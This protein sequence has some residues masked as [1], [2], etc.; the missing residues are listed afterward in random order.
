MLSGRR[1]VQ[2]RYWQWLAGRHGS[3]YLPWTSKLTSETPFALPSPPQAPHRSSTSGLMMASRSRGA[4]SIALNLTNVDR[5]DE[6]LYGVAVWNLSGSV[7]SSPPARLTVTIGPNVV[8][9]G[10]NTL[11]QAVPSDLTNAVAISVSSHVLA[12]RSDGTV[13]AWG[14]NDQGQATV[15]AGLSNVTAVAAGWY[16]RTAWR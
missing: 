4:N 1:P 12:L 8:I 7:T 9:W 11:V 6:G 16:R 5:G 14:L 10:T 13:T 15:P 2:T 3:H